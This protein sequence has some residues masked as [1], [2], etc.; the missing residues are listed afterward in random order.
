MEVE[1]NEMHHGSNKFDIFLLSPLIMDRSDLFFQPF[2]VVRGQTRST[3]DK[4]S[5]LHPGQTR[6]DCTPGIT[7]MRP[8]GGRLTIS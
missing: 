8:P 2:I 5:I 6:K 1:C 3:K 7:A 4:V